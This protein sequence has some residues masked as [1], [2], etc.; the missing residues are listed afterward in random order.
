MFLAWR[1]EVQRSIIHTP[2][3][4]VVAGFRSQEQECSSSS[5]HILYSVCFTLG[6]LLALPYF[7]IQA[8]TRKKYLS[9]LAQRL[10]FLS[11][12]ED[13]PAQGGIWIHAVSVG[14]VL[15]A[16]PLTQALRRRLPDLPLLVSTTTITGQNLAHQK[17]VGI[18]RTLYFPL[19]WNFSV[20]R[21]LNQIRPR[22]VL[23]IETEI[24]PNFLREC[25]RRRIPVLLING[26][27]SD[28]S[29]TRYRSIRWFMRRTLGYFNYCCMQSQADL[30]RIRTLGAAPE[31]SE[32]CGNLKY[33]LRF[34]EGV[35]A[36]TEAYRRLLR[37]NDGS[38][39]VVAGSTMKG[40]E[41]LVL[42]AFRKLREKSAHAILLLAPRHPER[43]GEVEQLLVQQSFCFRRR[44]TLTLDG[45]PDSHGPVE[46]ILLDSVGELATLYALAD[47]VFIGGSL[48]PTGGHNPLEPAL[49]RKPVLFGPHMSNFREM[50]ADFI[51]EG[52]AV[53]VQGQDTLAEK[54]VELYRH[55]DLGKEIGER[56]F[57]IIAGN[58][59]ATDRIV[60][61]IEEVL[62]AT[63]ANR[64]E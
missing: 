39:L 2:K 4:R 49:Y 11:V 59:G 52:A 62:P 50:A 21:S 7:L 60:K 27:I 22:L 40:E 31:T 33:D 30:D 24:W 35:E 46:V 61:R 51:R 47:V 18:A 9:N 14:E 53:Q 6:F 48:V 41:L 23:I 20:R 25:R 29:I 55:P 10:G 38:F 64:L 17:L 43:F 19:D 58:R 57:Q 56:G 15:A 34:P 42:C 1:E 45:L 36:K 28:Q 8:V 26:R 37:L 44:S 32:V 5:M 12:P 63:V 54:F 16:L 3:P 13:G